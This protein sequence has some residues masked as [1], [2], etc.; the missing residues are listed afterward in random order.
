MT[1]RA[2]LSSLLS[3]GA[4][5]VLATTLLAC[6]GTAVGALGDA[7]AGSSSGGGSSGSSSG[8]GSGGSSSGGGLVAGCPAQVGPGNGHCSPVDLQCEYGS[9]PDLACDTVEICGSNGVFSASPTN[10]TAACP[11]SSPGANGCPSTYSGVT[12]GASCTPDGLE[13]GYP[14]GRCACTTPQSGPPTVGAPKPIWE[15]DQPATGCPEPRPRLGAPCTAAAT[16]TC[17]YGAC[18]LPNGAALQCLDGSWSQAPYPC[19]L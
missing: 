10:T 9:D 2:L 11:T 19:P 5:A 7:G 14:Q 17:D 3:L 13:C 8:G 16:L 15:C 4:F 12:I 1:S 6:G 18:T